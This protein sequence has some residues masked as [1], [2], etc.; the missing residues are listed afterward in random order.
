MMHLPLLL[1]HQH[2]IQNNH[3][4]NPHNLA[5]HNHNTHHKCCQRW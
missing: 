3:T 2:H 1:Q 4:I 5:K